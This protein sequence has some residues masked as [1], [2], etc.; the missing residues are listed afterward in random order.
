MTASQLS[1]SVAVQKLLPA[2]VNGSENGPREVAEKLGLLQN[3]NEDNLDPLVLSILEEFPEKVMAYKNGKKGL[4][5]F[6][7]G[8]LMRKTESKSRSKNCK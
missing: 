4:I 5:G 3:H 7:M 6:F 2:L 1:F 8:Q